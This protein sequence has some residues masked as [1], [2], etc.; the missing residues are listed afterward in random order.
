MSE[1]PLCGGTQRRP[2]VKVAARMSSR[3]MLSLI[4]I[5]LAVKAP[6]V[7]RAYWISVLQG[8]L[9]HKKMPPPGTTVGP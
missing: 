5:L 9:A 3:S 7:F 6:Y 4:K 2:C 8:Y 1:V